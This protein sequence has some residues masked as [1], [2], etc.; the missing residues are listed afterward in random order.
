MPSKLLYCSKVYHLSFPDHS[1]FRTTSHKYF[2]A[3]SISLQDLPTSSKQQIPWLDGAAGE[4]VSRLSSRQEKVFILEGL[5]TF[6][7]SKIYIRRGRNFTIFVENDEW[8]RYLS[9]W[10]VFK[11][12]VDAYSIPPFWMLEKLLII[13]VISFGTSPWKTAALLYKY[14]SIS[15]HIKPVLLAHIFVLMSCTFDRI[16][17]E[18]CSPK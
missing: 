5:A 10:I 14:K 18:I 16:Q 15:I 12:P 8:E 9:R 2:H 11:V 7:L 6:D 1:A 13:G 4:L 3:L 17:S